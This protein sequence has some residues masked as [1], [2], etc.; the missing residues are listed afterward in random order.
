MHHQV[1]VAAI[2]DGTRLGTGSDAAEVFGGL[3][4]DGALRRGDRCGRVGRRSSRP[5]EELAVRLRCLG[6]CGFDAGKFYGE[7]GEDRIH[8]LHRTPVEE[9]LPDS[10]TRAEDLAMVCPNCHDIIHAKRPWISVEE[11]REQ[12]IKAGHTSF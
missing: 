11:L 7:R 5:D 9:L 8:A 10:V 2:P 6:A 1:R 3:H 4:G 12:L